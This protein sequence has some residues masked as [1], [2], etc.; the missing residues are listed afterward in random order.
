MNLP[1]VCVK[2]RMAKMVHLGQIKI[3]KSK[4][5]F[6]C[7]DCLKLDRPISRTTRENNETRPERQVR[8]FLERF[9]P[10]LEVEAEYR[11]GEFIYDFAI[12]GHNLLIEIDSK[13]FHNFSRKQ[14]VRDSLKARVGPKWRLIRVQVGPH[15]LSDIETGILSHLK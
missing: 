3:S 7:F 2:C 4:K 1:E 10:K 14:A 11:L 8:E 15:L 9:N 13:A 12:H 5:T 6:I